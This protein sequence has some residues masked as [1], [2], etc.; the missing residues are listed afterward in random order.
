[1]NRPRTAAEKAAHYIIMLWATPSP[2]LP[3]Q[4]VWTFQGVHDIVA[5]AIGEAGAEQRERIDALVEALR[6]AQVLLIAA[7]SGGISAVIEGIDAALAP[8]EKQAVTRTVPAG[9]WPAK[10]CE[11]LLLSQ[12]GDFIQVDS[13]ARL[14]LAVRAIERLGVPGVTVEVEEPKPVK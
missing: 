2:D 3:A 10:L 9:D 13:E 12:P 5:A 1:M 11:T 6:E 4:P 14:D 7:R 8:L